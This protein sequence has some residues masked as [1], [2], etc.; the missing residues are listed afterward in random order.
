MKF[1]R[2]FSQFQ[3]LGIDS[4]A[5]MI[6]FLVKVPQWWSEAEANKFYVVFFYQNLYIFTSSHKV[7]PQHK[8]TCTFETIFYCTPL[9]LLW[10]A[11]PYSISTLRFPKRR[12]RKA[13]KGGL[14]ETAVSCSVLRVD[15]WTRRLRASTEIQTSSSDTEHATIM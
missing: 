14:S 2:L 4:S 9:I 8:V 12:R 3:H 11:W 7:R 1:S 13:A 10:E 5:P 15:L 6:R